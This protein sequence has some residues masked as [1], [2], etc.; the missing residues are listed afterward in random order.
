MN[1]RVFPIIIY[2][3]GW[4]NKKTSNILFKHKKYPEM[5]PQQANIHRLVKKQMIK[6]S[7]FQQRKKTSKILKRMKTNIAQQLTTIIN[8]QQSLTVI[9]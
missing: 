7:N 2:K 5:F 4:N 9:N 1:V 6:V 3:L 8:N